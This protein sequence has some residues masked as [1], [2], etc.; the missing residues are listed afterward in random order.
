M[1]LSIQRCPPSEKPRRL[2]DWSVRDLTSFRDGR[3]AHKVGFEDRR[4]VTA[5]ETEKHGFRMAIRREMGKW[6]RKK[7]K[8]GARA[9]PVGT[10]A[11]YG[12]DDRRA[13]KLAAA[14]IPDEGAEPADLRRW[15]S[16]DGDLR[17]NGDVLEEV[18]AFF[19]AHGV[20]SVGII[21]AI[22]GCPHEE[23]VDYP[24][25]D[26]CPACRFWVGRDRWTGLTS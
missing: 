13:T 12:P 23:G 8:A 18:S 24:E 7:A 2:T 5:W 11:F 17:R 19:K 9:F 1:T 16:E 10:V 20:R 21:D 26:T 14:V 22:I 15:T 4:P 25:G 6:L 3:L